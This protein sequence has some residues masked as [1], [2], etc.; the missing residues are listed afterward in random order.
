MVGVSRDGFLK[1]GQLRSSVSFC[2]CGEVASASVRR[3]LLY[4]VEEEEAS[5]EQWALD[6]VDP[7]GFKMSYFSRGNNRER[8]EAISA[9]L[10][11][12]QTIIIEGDVSVR[13]GNTYFNAK[14]FL[15]P[16][17]TSI[18]LE[19]HNDGERDSN[20]QTDNCIRDGGVRPENGEEVPLCK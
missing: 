12:G 6:I 7:Y 9:K 14:R 5:R 1:N 4:R 19:K 3:F 2:W 13:R 11:Y 18:L 8:L 15:N 16:D 10:P 20:I 17:G